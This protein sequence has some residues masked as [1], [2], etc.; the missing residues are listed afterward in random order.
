MKLGLVGFGEAA[1]EMSV[2]LKQEGFEAI[3]AYD[4]M[5]NHPVFGTQIRER[6]S[7]AQVELLEAPGDL[8]NQ[9]EIVVVAVPAD[10]DYE[11]SE[12]LKPHL[13]K[14]CIYIDVTASTPNV[15]QN[16]WKNIQGEEVLFVDAAMMGPLPIYK[17][18]VPILASGNGTDQFIQLM[19]QY[20]MDITKVSIN[21]G[22]ASAVKLIRSI[23][24]KGVVAL[25]YELL[26]AAHTFNVEDLVIS[27]I[28][29]TME[30]K[31]FEQTMNRLVTGTA[32][33]ARRRSVELGGSI[34][35]LETSNINSAMSKAAREKLEGI[36]KLNL[37]AKFN[38]KQPG[39]WLEVIR[40]CQQNTATQA[41]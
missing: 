5:L 36:A 41:N 15:K 35:M 18:K 23:Y 31:T 30:G 22:E 17:H 13:K 8:L 7:Q 26:E 20:G 29:E 19:S 9:V 39:H 6:A 28:N 12:V 16:I 10:K 21:P 40:A 3:L 11:V 2:G 34:E 37:K 1:F 27:S 4:V 25:Y 32:I 24:M 14:G 38:G 33:H